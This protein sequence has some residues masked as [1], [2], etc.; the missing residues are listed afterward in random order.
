MAVQPSNVNKSDELLM[1]FAK[2][3]HEEQG[4]RDCVILRMSGQNCWFTGS[5]RVFSDRVKVFV[6]DMN[7]GLVDLK[8]PCDKMVEIS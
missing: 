4:P 2:E 8:W 5:V 6:Y 7:M 1:A 3:E